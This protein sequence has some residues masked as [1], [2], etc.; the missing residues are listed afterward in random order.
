MTLRRVLVADDY[1]PILN[2]VDR[3]IRDSFEVVGLVTDGR[4][5]VEAILGLE[6][7]IAVLDIAMPGM[8]G[9]EV[10]KEIKNRANKTPIVFLT[11]N[12]DSD[13]WAACLE[14][15]GAGYVAKES[16]STDLVLALNE[17]IAGRTFVSNFSPD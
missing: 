4:A 7:D 16:M 2:V 8:S 15:G 9:I 5:A 10:A 13:I 3:L 17:V 6:P 14:V 1:V 11:A 12:K